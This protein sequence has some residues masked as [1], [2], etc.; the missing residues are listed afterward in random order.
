MCRLKVNIVGN[1]T[2][3]KLPKRN[4]LNELCKM[5]SAHAVPI[6]QDIQ[7]MQIV[8][9]WVSS[10]ALD[11]SSCPGLVFGPLNCLILSFWVYGRSI[12]AV[13]LIIVDY[14]KEYWHSQSTPFPWMKMLCVK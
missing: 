9:S 8:T 12:F 6:M 5:V 2:Y 3:F 11:S 1:D 4:Y 14:D 10:L 7:D 13:Q